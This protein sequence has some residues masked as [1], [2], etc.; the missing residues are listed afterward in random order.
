MG[1]TK[2]KEGAYDERNIQVMEGLEAVRKRPGMYI[3]DT[4]ARGF[5]HLLWEILDN[6]IDEAMAGHC[7]NITIEFDDRS[8][9]VT[10][11]GRGIPTG[12]HP[13]LGIPACEV[14]LTVLHAG[15]KFDKGA[16][17]V[18]GG[19][20]GVGASVVNA[21]SEK[22]DLTVWRDG[23]RH[24]QSYR[25]GLRQSDLRKVKDEAPSGTS[26]FFVPDPEIFK[27]QKFEPSLIRRRIEEVSFLVPGLT[28]TVC[29]VLSGK[30][31]VFCHRE[32]LVSCIES[33]TASLDK[34]F[35]DPITVQ[36][37]RDGTEVAL[38]LIYTTDY[39][40]RIY[41]YVNLIPTHEGGTHVTGFRAALTRAVNESSRQQGLLK[42]RESNFT[43]EDLKEGL[44][45]ILS[46]KVPDPQFEGQTKTKLGNSETASIVTS[47][48]YEEFMKS[49]ERNKAVL[50]A[51]VSKAKVSRD[52]R[53]AARKA[54]SAV[55]GIRN[56][57]PRTDMP[58]KLADCSGKKDRELFLVEGDSAGGSAKQ[59]RDR[60]RQA[61]LP[62]RGKVLN[63]ERARIDKALSNAEIQA[64]IRSLGCGIGEDYNEKKLRYDRV[65]LMADADVDG[66]HITTLLLTFFFRM[67]PQLILGGRVF[68][69]TPPLYRVRDGKGVRYLYSD[70]ELKKEKGGEK[71]IQRFKGLGEMSAEQLWETTMCPETRQLRIVT[72][73]DF[74]ECDSITS[75]LM[76]DKV[77]LRRE[78]LFA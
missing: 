73:E 29:N 52:S 55:R 24:E 35:P 54:R 16:Y 40:E 75:C 7:R 12:I 72:V 59:G 39:T 58:A 31:E 78:F 22:L 46:V 5:H 9:R 33:R 26:I 1:R 44:M 38:A 49:F 2:G 6:S 47:S 18:S 42:D 45:A 25:K 77:D 11:D 66:A 34:V 41:S 32:G 28:L 30:K 69:A 14:V 64:I 50:K 61:I 60:D 48:L 4:G 56:S 37:S 19:L 53:E 20:H 21:L 70:R 51:I 8:C 65:I 57:S 71:T 3:G 43:G 10:D 15:G 63:C 36:D 62:L 13:K 67:M 23:Y 76:G 68:L 27:G 74:G 17:T